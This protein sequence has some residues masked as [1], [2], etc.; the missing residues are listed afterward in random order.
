MKRLAAALLASFLAISP[1]AADVLLTPHPFVPGSRLESWQRLNAY[2]LYQRLRGRRWLLRS[3]RI[4]RLWLYVDQDSRRVA[5]WRGMEC[6]KEGTTTGSGQKISFVWDDGDRE[7]VRALVK[8]GKVAL[9]PRDPRSL[10]Q[11]DFIEVRLAGTANFR[12]CEK[13]LF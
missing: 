7:P 13:L 2:D 10:K 12:P 8:E 11:R 3:P 5:V 6:L 4:G 9:L 1:A